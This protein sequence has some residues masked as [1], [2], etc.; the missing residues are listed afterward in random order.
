MTNSTPK[1][2]D[3]VDLSN[4]DDS[5]LISTWD[6]ALEE[7]N[8][9]FSIDPEIREQEL[10]ACFNE[11]EN[12]VQSNQSESQEDGEIIQDS[13][14]CDDE[15]SYDQ[16]ND[17]HHGKHGKHG[18]NLF[19][20][21]LTATICQDCFLPKSDLYEEITHFYS[22]GYASNQF[23]PPRNLNQ[24]QKAWYSAGFYTKSSS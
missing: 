17:S 19:L 5:E 18:D 13:D 8:K 9:Y 22:L 11:N 4:W 14:G 1:Q 24:F 10:P 7:Y 15:H 6:L 16:H 3:F 23:N 2:G 21:S 12:E 20:E